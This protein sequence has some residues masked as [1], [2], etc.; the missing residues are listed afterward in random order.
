MS[1]DAASHAA[2]VS[3]GERKQ[4]YCG[5]WTCSSYR[6][7]VDLNTTQCLCLASRLFVKPSATLFAAS[8]AISLPQAWST[9][10]AEFLPTYLLTFSGRW[11]CQAA[12]P[13]TIHGVEDNVWSRT[14]WSLPN[15]E[16]QRKGID[17][18]ELPTNRES[19]S[20]YRAWK[21]KQKDGYRS[22]SYHSRAHVSSSPPLPRRVGFANC[23]M[24]LPSITN[25]P[26]GYHLHPSMRGCRL[27]SKLLTATC[28]GL[29]SRIISC[30]QRINCVS[31][32]RSASTISEHGCEL[33]M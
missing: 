14:V 3:L 13:A 26:T 12:Y 4:K 16:G 25:R 29:T 18:S 31:A 30:A 27:G 6:G 23:T 9:H 21:N 7:I 32:A 11:I 2:T 8:V 1:T 10:L 33:R 19:L 15:P 17:V 24:P 28:R 20:L 22:A 5:Q